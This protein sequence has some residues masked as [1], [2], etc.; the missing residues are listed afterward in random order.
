M[1]LVDK[2]RN[3][4]NLMIQEKQFLSSEHAATDLNDV[5]IDM[6]QEYSSELDDMKFI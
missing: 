5:H 4:V 3:K 2:L 1:Q 6:E